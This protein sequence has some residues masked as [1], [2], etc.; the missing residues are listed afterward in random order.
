MKIINGG[1][2][3]PSSMRYCWKQGRKR[4]AEERFQNLRLVRYLRSSLSAQAATPAWVFWEK[5]LRLRHR[6]RNLNFRLES[7]PRR[8]PYLEC[9]PI[10]AGRA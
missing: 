7:L 4:C 6:L 1:S 5:K 3:V 8:S 10:S 9:P 2:L